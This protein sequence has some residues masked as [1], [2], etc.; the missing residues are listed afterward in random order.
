MAFF[1]QVWSRAV[2]LLLCKV[3]LAS[4]SE[5]QLGPLRESCPSLTLSW[6]LLSSHGGRSP[7]IWNFH[8][9]SPP[10]FPL[11]GPL[12]SCLSPFF[13]SS[14]WLG[15]TEDSES[16]LRCT[17]VYVSPLVK[18]PC[19]LQLQAR[20]AVCFNGR[21]FLVTS[22]NCCPVFWYWWSRWRWSPLSMHSSSRVDPMN[23]CATFW[24]GAFH[25]HRLRNGLSVLDAFDRGP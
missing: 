12:A 16:S 22:S 18:L 23:L 17:A 4:S 15:W 8:A 14:A 21:L 3:S 6:S 9:R 24:Y 20:D 7:L 10:M 19:A 5:G 1:F 13:P 25:R 11:A 2:G